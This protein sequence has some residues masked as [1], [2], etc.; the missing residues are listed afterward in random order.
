MMAGGPGGLAVAPVG[1]DPS[2]FS[3][4]NGY[5][6]RSA[7][8]FSFA[9]TGDVRLEAGD[10]AGAR[11]DYR[12]AL[13]NARFSL[14]RNHPLVAEVRARLASLP[15]PA[16][17]EDNEKRLVIGCF[18]L[19]VATV[20]ICVG[21]TVVRDLTEGQSQASDREL[22]SVDQLVEVCNSN[23]RYFLDAAAF[24]GP[25]PHP[26]QVFRRSNNDT[27]FKRELFGGDV[28]PR[29][30]QLVA[31]VLQ[32]RT[33]PPVAS[34]KFTTQPEIPLHEATYQVTIYETWTGRRLGSYAL[35][36]NKGQCPASYAPPPQ[37]KPW[38]LYVAPSDDQY[39]QALQPVIDLLP[40][41]TSG[42]ASPH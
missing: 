21:F 3:G 18:S 4:D 16:R 8:A 30:N 5:S 6:G 39:R 34:C 23:Q 1:L 29:K 40:V 17:D 12:A 33:G 25:D 35:T 36:A 2:S 11:R 31:C 14:P 26:A 27:A 24:A 38:M 9:Q 41:E 28:D 7:L 37:G 13:S 42:S 15:Q 10:H 32:T 19:V 20:L 22:A